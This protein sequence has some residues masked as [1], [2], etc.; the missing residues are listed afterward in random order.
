MVKLLHR[1][2]YKTIS[3]FINK[4]LS[5]VLCFLSGYD[6]E[7]CILL[8]ETIQLVSK[9]NQLVQTFLD[10]NTRENT[11]ERSNRTIKSQVDIGAWSGYFFVS[12][13]TQVHY[14]TTA[15]DSYTDLILLLDVLTKCIFHH[16]F[17]FYSNGHQG[18]L[19][20]ALFVYP[21]TTQ[22]GLRPV[23]LTES[24]SD[25]RS[26]SCY[27]FQTEKPIQLFMSEKEELYFK[28]FFVWSPSVDTIFIH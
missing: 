18:S 14:K 9:A 19:S 13:K 2:E 1:I 5:S 12:I 7:K 25:R 21:A 22:K 24:L 16:Y 17:P 10:T 28:K 3:I 27:T 6:W 26:T 23:R 4:S 11:S 20:G 8:S 15:L